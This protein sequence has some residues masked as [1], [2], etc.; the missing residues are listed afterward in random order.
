MKKSRGRKRKITETNSNDLQDTSNNCD[1]N[2]SNDPK[3]TSKTET[4]DID[5][6]KVEPDT[7]SCTWSTNSNNKRTRLNKTRELKKG[8][9]LQGPGHI[10][11]IKQV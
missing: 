1:S 5:S 9:T 8:K 7:S 11:R 2:I 4:K 3:Q 6:I 10:N